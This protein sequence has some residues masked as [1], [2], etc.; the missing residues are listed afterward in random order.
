MFDSLKARFILIL[1]LAALS[2]WTLVDR[3]VLLGLDLRPGKDRGDLERMMRL[4][5][6]DGL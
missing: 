2:V 3:G 6:D 1:A 5:S 4:L